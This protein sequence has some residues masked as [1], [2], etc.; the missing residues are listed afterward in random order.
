MSDISLGFLCLLMI[1]FLIYGSMGVSQQLTSALLGAKVDSNFQRNLK[2]FIQ[3]VG[4]AIWSGLGMVVS[5]GASLVPQSSANLVGKVLKVA[6][7]GNALRAKLH[8]WAGRK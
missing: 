8:N 6:K 1:G 4:K 3:G 7:K 5:W 2:A